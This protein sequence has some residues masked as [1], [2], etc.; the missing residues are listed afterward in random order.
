[1]ARS[2]YETGLELKL[3]LKPSYQYR[4]IVENYILFEGHYQIKLL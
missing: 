4:K 3:V 1:M 2:R